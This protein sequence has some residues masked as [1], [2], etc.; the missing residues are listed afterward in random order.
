MCGSRNHER[1]PAKYASRSV[2]THSSVV[3]GYR[4]LR[5][6]APASAARTS[7]KNHPDRKIKL[8]CPSR[9]SCVYGLE[10]YRVDHLCPL[11]NGSRITPYAELTLHYIAFSEFVLQLNVLAATKPRWAVY[12]GQI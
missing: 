2:P 6:G 8:Q 12:L 1:P 5:A 9:D 7:G 3:D 10:T 4:A 11:R